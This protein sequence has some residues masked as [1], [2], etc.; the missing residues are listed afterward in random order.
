MRIV[1]AGSSG[2]IG[3]ALAA[4]LESHGHA[5]VRLRR[6]RRDEATAAVVTWDPASG[7]LDPSVLT[8]ADAVVNL[9][10]ANIAAARW[11]ARRKRLLLESRVG[12]TALLARAIAALGG[13]APVFLSASAIGYYGSGGD[14]DMFDEGVGPGGDFLAEIAVAWEAAARP[15]ADAGARVV[16]P[17]FGNVL[18]PEGGMLARILTPFR[19]GLG[20]RI[21]SGRQWMSWITLDDALAVL[22]FLIEDPASRGAFNLTAPEPVTNAAFAAALGRALCRPAVLP[23][24]APLISLVLGEMGRTLLL[25]GSRVLPR[26]LLEAGFRFTQPALGSALAQLLGPGP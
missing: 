9:C 3:R 26:R 8:G 19:I 18:S 7:R 22:E 20:G 23:L 24:P 2:F 12:P 16:Y 1:I 6:V 4:R 17:R 25:A 13:S 11:T 21:G 15:A 10:G 5:V 14:G